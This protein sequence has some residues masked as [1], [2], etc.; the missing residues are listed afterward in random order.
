MVRYIQPLT[1]P[2]SL[3]AHL[4]I[5]DACAEK[6]YKEGYQVCLLAR[7]ESK[8]DAIAT[9]LGERA[10]SYRCDVSVASD[11]E[12]VCDKILADY[13]RVDTLI[14]NAGSGKFASFDESSEDDLLTSLQTGPVGLFRFAKRLIPVML[15]RKSGVIA[16]TGATASWRGMPSTSCFA[17]AKSGQRALAMSLAREFG[18]QGINVFHVVVDGLVDVESTRKWFSKDESDGR[19]IKP[20]KIADHYWFMANQDERCRTFETSIFSAERQLDMLNI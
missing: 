18:P 3:S 8:L 15:E 2:S 16:V 1:F 11:I 6:W 13:G 9:S 7:T 10:V 4:G 19:F 17:P 12:A 5:G 14:Y 20:D